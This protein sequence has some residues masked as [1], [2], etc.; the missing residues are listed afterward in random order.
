MTLQEIIK[1]KCAPTSSSEIT[2]SN[3]RC[4]EASG[5]RGFKNEHSFLTRTTWSSQEHTTGTKQ[6]RTS[7]WQSNGTRFSVRERQIQC[8]QSVPVLTLFIGIIIIETHHTFIFISSHTAAQIKL[9]DFSLSDNSTNSKWNKK[10]VLT[11]YT[12]VTQSLLTAS[13]TVSARSLDTMYTE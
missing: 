10:T 1:L 12:A 7:D 2:C 4:V 8:Q 13:M 9:W 11:F 3:W 5:F 6:T